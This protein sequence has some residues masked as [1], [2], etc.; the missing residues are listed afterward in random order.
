MAWTFE[1]SELVSNDIPCSKGTSPNPSQVILLTVD[2]VFKHINPWNPFSLK[3]PPQATELRPTN[4]HE[5]RVSTA[6]EC[7]GPG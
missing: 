1:S 2:Q 5:G 3:P 4:D 7:R 6:A